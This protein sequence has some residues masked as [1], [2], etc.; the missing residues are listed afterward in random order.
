MKDSLNSEIE[1]F[2][3]EHPE[4]ADALRT[5]D[6]SLATYAET[7]RIMNMIPP[8][9]ISTGLTSTGSIFPDA[10]STANTKLI[11]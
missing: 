5:F 8:A 1:T 4:I 7:L 10:D 11:A 2:L 6:E 9:Q 3:S